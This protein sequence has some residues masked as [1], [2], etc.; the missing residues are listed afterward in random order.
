MDRG[1]VHDLGR[2]EQDRIRLLHAT[3]NSSNLKTYELLFSGI[4]RLIFSYQVWLQVSET[5]ESETTDKGR[6]LYLLL[7][8]FL[9]CDRRSEIVMSRTRSS[10]QG[11][12]RP[13]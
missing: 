3:Q 8:N 1:V 11:L 12:N 10:P 9:A 5:L 4:F 7:I 2:I 13:S 6:L